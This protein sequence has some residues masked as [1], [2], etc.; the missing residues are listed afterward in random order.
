MKILFLDIDGVLNS[1]QWFKALYRTTGKG[2]LIRDF[3]PLASS[4]LLSIL[5]EVPDLS[6]VISSSWRRRNTLEQLR[7][8]LSEYH[9]APERV[10]GVTPILNTPRGL[11]IQA[12][13]DEHPEV[14]QFVIVD[15][16]ADMEH[17]LPH[18]VR[19]QWIMGLMIDKAREIIRRF[20]GGP[21]VDPDQDFP[22]VIPPNL[23]S[24]PRSR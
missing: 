14:T 17:L 13:L 8:I 19:T 9:V 10:I 3:C 1:S 23:E 22:A 6:I 16:S 24:N 12:W 18:L 2:G 21:D 15:D 7:E 4:N 11:E 5:Q 20:N